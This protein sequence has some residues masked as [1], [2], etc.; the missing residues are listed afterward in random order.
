LQ[1]KTSYLVQ[2][3]LLAPYIGFLEELQPGIA[4]DLYLQSLTTPEAN[5]Q[6]FNQLGLMMV[7]HDFGVRITR[8]P[9]MLPDRICTEL[10]I[11]NEE[12]QA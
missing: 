5:E 12:F 2:T 7:S 4:D 10:F 1:L 9:C 8:L 11:A 6:Y 3:S